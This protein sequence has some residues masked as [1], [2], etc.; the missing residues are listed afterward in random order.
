MVSKIYNE[1]KAKGHTHY[2]KEN[3]VHV[4][5]TDQQYS[6]LQCPRVALLAR[7]CQPMQRM[8]S[9][10]EWHKLCTNINSALLNNVLQ[11]QEYV[12]RFYA[13]ICEKMHQSFT[14]KLD[15]TFYYPIFQ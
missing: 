14:K 9:L 12:P 5:S 4:R 10:P 6:E 1:I 2:N 8:P 15:M 7:H 3:T 13:N 11:L